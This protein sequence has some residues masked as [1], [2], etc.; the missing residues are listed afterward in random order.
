MDLA[1][2]GIVKTV[3]FAPGS[4]P[5]MLRVSPDGKYV[6]VQTSVANTNVVLDVET[7]ETLHTTPVGREPVQLA[8]GPDDGR[9]GLITHFADTFVAVLD[10][11]TGREVRRIDVGQ[12]QANAVFTPDG[13]VAF[14]TVT[15][16]DE[17]VV[18]DM[19]QLAVIARLKTGNEP[20]GLVLLDRTAA[21]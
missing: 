19:A 18:I 11:R 15:G 16:G 3:R 14:V 12:P 1:T 21:S 20:M 5:Y 7:M 10:R 9:Y 13:A 8:F 17:I 2:R 6:W 4:K